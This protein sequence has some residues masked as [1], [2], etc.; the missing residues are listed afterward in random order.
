MN[1]DYPTDE[2]LEK[3]SAWP[4]TDINGGLE[5]AVSL[6]HWPEYIQ[7]EDGVLY[8]ATG[9]WSGNESIISAMRGNIGI[10]SRWICSSRGGAHEFELEG[11]G[12]T[13]ESRF[14]LAHKL[15]QSRQAIRD[16]EREHLEA[17][18][19]LDEVRAACD[20][21]HKERDE[22][23]VMVNTQI[24]L[25]NESTRYIQ[26]LQ[27]EKRITELKREGDQIEQGRHLA[28]KIWLNCKCGSE[29]DQELAGAIITEALSRNRNQS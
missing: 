22:A 15:Q 29:Y 11:Y 10:G 14:Q 16:R 8:M 19:E 12:K 5:Y 3:L 25:T 20:S 17:C 2:E 27:A 21:L 1:D 4:F 9:G 7:R 23:L 26:K 18:A 6:W 13:R 24:D 28:L